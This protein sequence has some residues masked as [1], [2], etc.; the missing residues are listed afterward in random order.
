[1]LIHTAPLRRGVCPPIPPHLLCHLGWLINSQSQYG[2]I[3]P[4]K[5][6]EALHLIFSLSLTRLLRGRKDYSRLFDQCTDESDS[7]RL[8][9]AW[10]LS[11][12]F[13]S[14]RDKLVFVMTASCL[15]L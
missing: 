4:I 13:K 12:E 10:E 3:P 9:E 8:K 11:F 7:D 5:Q 14:E 6:M 2:N 1:M 15:A